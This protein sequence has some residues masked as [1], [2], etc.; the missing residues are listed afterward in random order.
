MIKML[1]EVRD[2]E[3]GLV[4]N[5]VVEPHYFAKEFENTPIPIAQKGYCRL[6]LT[7]TTFLGLASTKL[8]PTSFRLIARTTLK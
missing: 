7:D 8:I 5:C 3:T 2:L 4:F 6:Y 1:R